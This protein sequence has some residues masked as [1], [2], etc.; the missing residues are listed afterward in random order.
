MQ[1]SIVLTHALGTKEG[2]EWQYQVVMGLRQD[3]TSV[4]TSQ[5][6]TA[7]NM[8]AWHAVSRCEEILYPYTDVEA[9]DF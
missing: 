5:H 3:W 4:G 7:E 2:W 8:L 9:Y 1:L 6:L